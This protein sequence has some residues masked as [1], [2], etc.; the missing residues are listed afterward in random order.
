[1]PVEPVVSDSTLKINQIYKILQ[2]LLPDNTVVKHMDELKDIKF[3]EFIQIF[4]S[5]KIEI[6]DD[7]NINNLLAD[8][9]NQIKNTL[10]Y[11]DLSASELDIAVKKMFAYNETVTSNNTIVNN[12]SKIVISDDEKNKDVNV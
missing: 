12:L 2:D 10:N 8:Y 5:G 6:G 7:I 9:Y 4:A 3:K 11:D 1:M